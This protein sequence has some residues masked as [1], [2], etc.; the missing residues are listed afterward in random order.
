M[1]L[2]ASLHFSPQTRSAQDKVSGIG[3]GQRAPRG[4]GH[5]DLGLR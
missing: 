4:G 2:Q 1:V 3:G 5:S